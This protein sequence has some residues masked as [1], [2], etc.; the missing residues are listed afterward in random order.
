MGGGGGGSLAELYRDRET[1]WLAISIFSRI[2]KY[3]LEQ[4]WQMAKRGE[5]LW[6][7]L[8][9]TRLS[10][11][12]HCHLRS[13]YF[14]FIRNLLNLPARDIHSTHISVIWINF[15]EVIIHERLHYTQDTLISECHQRIKAAHCPCNSVGIATI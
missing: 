1:R 9:R 4:L 10:R 3:T 14:S 15:H 2:C 12:R 7:E 8:S 6:N 11:R 13:G 5:S